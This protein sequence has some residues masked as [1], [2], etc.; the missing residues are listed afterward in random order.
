[1][2]KLPLNEFYKENENLIH[3]SSQKALRRFSAA[4]LGERVEYD[5]IFGE[6]REVFVKS[7]NQF[8]PKQSKFSTY[9]VAATYNHITNR[10]EKMYRMD[11]K[12]DSFDVQVGEDDESVSL[13]DVVCNYDPMLEES[14]ALESEIKHLRENLSL[15]AQTLLD[16]S[17]NPP[18]FMVDEF[19][20]QRAQCTWAT[21]NGLK[22]SHSTE[23]NLQ[24]VA[25]CLKMTTDNPET[26]KCIKRAVDEVKHAV[27]RAVSA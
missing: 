19:H 10:I 13:M 14:V 23:I 18:Q 8:D 17:I 22:T 6:L 26:L 20:A 7:Y 4:G 5:E 15:F 9:Y 27:Q 16:Y 1:M 24:F 25:N 12:L 3:F 11:I 2:T 21:S